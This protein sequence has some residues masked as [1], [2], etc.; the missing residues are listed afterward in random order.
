MAPL[1]GLNATFAG[2]MAQPGSIAFLSQS[3]ALCTAILD[4]SSRER[5]GFSAFVSTGSMLDVGWGDLIDYLGGD[6]RTRA[7]LMYME[8]VG[9]ARKFLSA[10]REVAL[11]KP[12]IVL[13]AGRTE[14]AARAAC[15]HTGALTGSDEV[16]DAALGRCG[17]LRVRRISDLFYMADVLAKQHRP[18]GPR[19]AIVT[20]AGGPGVL[21]T[22]ALIAEGGELAELSV[23]TMAELD[24]ILPPHWSRHNPIDIIGDAPPSRYAKALE[25]VSRDPGV[26][27][28]LVSLA[29]QGMTSP[30]EV[31]EFVAPFAKTEGKP[32]LASFMGAASVARADEILRAS[33]IPAFS[34]PDTA[35]R[36]FAYMWHYSDNLRALYET[37]ELAEASVNREAAAAL[38]EAARAE[39][40]TLLAEHE[41][42]QL[43]A[44]YAIPVA[45]T[46]LAKTEEQAIELAREIGFPAVVKLHSRRSRTR[47]T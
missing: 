6:P 45:R 24:K 43:L 30:S 1:A 47:P 14:Q 5:V 9:D 8:S 27:G 15:S 31:A 46:E 12:I 22:D 17:V 38:L 29:P 35:A 10:A 32:V 4:W 18:N 34:F 26:D 21:A 16:L 37:P 7:I 40:R 41:S 44:A 13:K 19:L 42:K 2:A 20:N 28:L 39:R 11:T 36:A 33:G 23:E 3:G 25:I